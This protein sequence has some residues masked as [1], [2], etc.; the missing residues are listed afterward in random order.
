MPSSYTNNLGIELPAD[1][2]LDGLWGDV[3][4]DNMGILDRAINGS[5]TLTLSGT[6]STLTT[7]DGT[8][9]DGQYKVLVL[10]GSPSG[11]HTITIAPNDAQKIYFVRNTTAQSVVFT[12]GS[13][14]NA[15]IAAGDNAIIYSTGGGAASAVVVV[16][17]PAT[18]AQLGITASAAELN[19][20]DGITASTAELN[21]LDGNT[22][23]GDM[24]VDG[25]TFFV[26][27]TNN[28]VGIGTTSPSTLLSLYSSTSSTLTVSGDS[29]TTI[30]GARYS[31]DTTGP[32][33]NQRKHRG[34]LASPAA[35]QTNDSMGAQ[36]FS[37]YD[38]ASL[39]TTAQIAAA[40]E[41]F[42]G[43]GD[44]SGRITFSTRPTGGGSSLTERM[45]IRADGNVGIG[46]SSPA[47]LLHVN[48][49]VR[50]T[51]LNL[52]GTVVTASAAELNFVVGVTSDIQTQLDSRVTSNADDTLTG[53]YTTTAVDDGTKSSGTYTPSPAGGNMKRIVNGGAFTL[54]APTASG[55]Y[56]IVIQ[57]TNN[58]SAGAI[59]TTGFN[60]VVGDVFTTTDGHDFFVFITK[61]NGFLSA[62]VQALQ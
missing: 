31:N 33:I 52:G 16:I 24:D 27:S 25:G 11:T 34:T 22:F 44:V 8:L 20:L 30:V 62:N 23:T 53:G 6:S 41:S 12:Q 57:I 55:D 50:A 37:A 46:T 39:L 13:G 40:V 60:R 1:G 38:G 59:T 58:A 21:Q 10:A 7:S 26:D 15:T 14:G 29:T 17:P 2:E 36:S 9:S 43:V 61:C 56:T 47:E 54:A 19:V 5:V 48:G 49:T 35:V 51:G 42:V 4:N 18:L 45:R 28:R 32:A 3:V